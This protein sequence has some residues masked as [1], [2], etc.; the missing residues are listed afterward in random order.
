MILMICILTHGCHRSSHYLIYIDIIVVIVISFTSDLQ[1][2]GAIFLVTLIHHNNLAPATALRHSQCPAR[3]QM[4]PGVVPEDG[5]HFHVSQKNKN[6]TS[7]F[8]FYWLL[9]RDLL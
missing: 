9:N 8:P 3:Q 6:K 5:F 4:T 2:L 1:D 7:H